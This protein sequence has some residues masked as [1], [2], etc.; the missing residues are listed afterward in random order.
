MD[1]VN[2]G[3]RMSERFARGVL[4]AVSSVL[5]PVLS[6]SISI[7]LGAQT[8]APVS[9][10]SLPAQK[11]PASIQQPSVD[12]TGFNPPE[13]LASAV[14]VIQSDAFSE[15]QLLR[16]EVQELRGLVETLNF[17]LQQVD[18]KSVV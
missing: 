9:D 11:V 3:I 5:V 1:A 18:R 12:P 16:A 14:P 13:K 4:R 6:A 17:R 8:L 10:L 2:A 15:L 7:G